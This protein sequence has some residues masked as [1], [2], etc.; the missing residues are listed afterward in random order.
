[1]TVETRIQ[2]ALTELE[3]QHQVTILLA[4]ESGSRAWGFASPDSDYDVR[5]VYAHER[6]WY[7]TVFEQRDVIELPV[8]AVLD[9]SGWDIRKALRLLWKC[10]GSLLEWLSSPIVY[11]DHPQLTQLKQLA[12]QAFMPQPVCHHYLSLARGQLRDIESK[13]QVRPK[14][15]LYALRPLLCCQW[16]IRHQTQPPMRFAELSS[17]LLTAG[18]LRQAID[19]LLAIKS[20]SGE[21]ATI[22]RQTIL[23]Q[24]IS[25]QTQALEEQIPNQPR[26]CDQAAFDATFRTIING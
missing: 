15:Y 18:A 16:I 5:F 22:N 19:E 12:E 26:S 11:R 1:M 23:D 4:I 8:D 2:A 9:I 17:E 21:A 14:T 10:N 6:D 3:Q 25:Q 24:F 20:S 7:L 13:Q